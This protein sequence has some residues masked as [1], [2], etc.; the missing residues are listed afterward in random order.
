MQAVKLLIKAPFMFIGSLLDVFLALWVIEYFAGGF[1]K[2]EC[3]NSTISEILRCENLQNIGVYEPL[4]FRHFSQSQGCFN[5]SFFDNNLDESTKII[6]AFNKLH[7]LPTLP[8]G[9]NEAINLS[10]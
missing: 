6:G 3:T 9:H 10:K 8:N 4:N 1:C 5:C 2:C 7:L